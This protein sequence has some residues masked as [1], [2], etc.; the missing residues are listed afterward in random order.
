MYLRKSGESVGDVVMANGWRVYNGF[1]LQKCW[2]H[3]MRDAN[4]FREF[5]GNK[6]SSEIHLKF[7]LRD[8]LD[9]NLPMEGRIDKT[10]LDGEMEE[11]V[12]KH[13]DCR[14]IEKPMT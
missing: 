13:E 1:A 9:K 7:K 6:R 14:K 10:R 3:L 2:F 8:L 11:L 4:D 12:K 5:I